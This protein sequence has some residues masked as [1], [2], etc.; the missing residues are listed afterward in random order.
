[1]FSDIEVRATEY[2]IDAL[3]K[4]CE[5]GGILGIDGVKD[6]VRSISCQRNTTYF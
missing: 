1:M 2:L 4:N 5:V 3:F 6:V